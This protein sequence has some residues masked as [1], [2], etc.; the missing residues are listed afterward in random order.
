METCTFQIFW[1]DRVLT[2]LFLAINR[3]HNHFPL[4]TCC[5]THWKYFFFHHALSV[6][7]YSYNYR[8]P[9]SI[10]IIHLFFFS[11]AVEGIHQW[12]QWQ[13]HSLQPQFFSPWQHVQWLQKVLKG[14]LRKQL[15]HVFL[16]SPWVRRT[17]LKS[18]YITTVFFLFFF[19]IDSFFHHGSEEQHLNLST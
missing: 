18:V 2:V 1:S 16:F 6:P 17:T 9:M 10:F 3:F 7:N 11:C 14:K 15:W 19:A 5:F 4:Q 8:L 12:R 13:S